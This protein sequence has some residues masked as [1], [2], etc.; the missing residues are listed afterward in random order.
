MTLTNSRT[1]QSVQTTVS[2]DGSYSAQIGAQAGDEI[3]VMVSDIAGNESASRVLQVAG[4]P[5]A[6][7]LTVT[8]PTEGATFDENRVALLGSYQGPANVGVSVNGTPA[9]LIGNVLC[10]D[11]PLDVGVNTLNVVAA[12]PDGS[13][14]S[15]SLTVTSTGSGPITLAA[16]STRGLAPLLV[17]FSLSGI[18]GLALT[19]IDYDFDGNGTV[20]YS[21]ND[22]EEAV[23]HTYPTPGCYLA[24]VSAHDT[25]SGDTMTGRR[26]IAVEELPGLDGKLRAIFQ[27]ML[28]RIRLGD[29]AG[30]VTAIVPER[31]GHFSTFFTNFGPDLSSFVDGIGQLTGGAF[32][33]DIARYAVVR[34]V[35]GKP[36]VFMLYFVKGDDGIWRIEEM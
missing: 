32:G 6:L 24:S 18:D 20:D 23:A 17:N 31:A 26:L 25:V 29:I 14:T 12:L 19:A 27:G 5:P 33:T 9:A 35:N 28:N 11:V 36:M 1:G 3:L 34:E 4:A 16:D 7:G 30:A 8:S 22:P 10:A 15:Q 2:G 21:T 13:S